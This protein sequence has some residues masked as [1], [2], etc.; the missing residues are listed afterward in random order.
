MSNKAVKMIIYG[1]I[2][3]LGAFIFFIF[4][5]QKVSPGTVKY[6]NGYDTF[7][8]EQI[9][10]QHGP[11]Y[12]TTIYINNDANPYYIYTRVSPADAEKLSFEK[13]LPAKVI[14][15][16]QVYITINPSENLTGETTIAALEID[17]FIDN[18]YLY[19]TPVNSAFTEPYQDYPIKTCADADNETAI[20][21]LTLGSETRAYSQGECIVLQGSTQ[22]DIVALA[23]GLIFR[24]LKIVR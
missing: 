8:V 2:I 19:N 7:N 4:F 18:S 22:S 12:K 20:I 15:K 23:D 16:K 9:D 6:F 17:K 11:T 10:T 3:V 13:G 14:G 21:F 1:M 5:N 24:M